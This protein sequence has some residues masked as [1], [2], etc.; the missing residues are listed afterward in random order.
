MAWK[1]N[2]N[3]LFT[4]MDANQIGL[5]GGACL[6]AILRR[7]NV[8]RV[9]GNTGKMPGPFFKTIACEQAPTSEIRR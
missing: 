2:L 9:I 7:G 3:R 6:Q 1:L 5:N 8:A 4:L